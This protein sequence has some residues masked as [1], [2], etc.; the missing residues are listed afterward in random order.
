[1]KIKCGPLPKILFGVPLF[2][3]PVS[4]YAKLSYTEDNWMTNTG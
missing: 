3:N 1:M 2:V 4:A